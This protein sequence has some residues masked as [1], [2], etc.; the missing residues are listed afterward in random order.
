MGQTFV[1][2]SEK[3]G[4]QQLQ[5]GDKRTTNTIKGGER[6]IRE[7][8]GH[9][10]CIVRPIDGIR[11]CSTKGEW[12]NEWSMF[13]TTTHHHP[14]RTSTWHHDYYGDVMGFLNNRCHIFS[15]DFKLSMY[16]HLM[17]TFSYGIK[18]VIRSEAPPGHTYL[19]GSNAQQEWFFSS[20]D[21]TQLNAWFYSSCQVYKPDYKIDKIE[22]IDY[23]N[24]FDEENFDFTDGGCE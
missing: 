15:E 19:E 9:P 23:T 13:I 8:S 1:C 2:V 20:I 7:F 4:S 18:P 12:S 22:H 10:N 21:Q 24:L 17:E 14:S 16:R 11:K 6:V 5:E 3:D